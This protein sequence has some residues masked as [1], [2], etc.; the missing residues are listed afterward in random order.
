MRYR[1]SFRLLR[2]KPLKVSSYDI[3]VGVRIGMS[4]RI[5]YES[6]VGFLPKVLTGKI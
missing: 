5:Q 3:P 2:I 6:A 1:K 4:E